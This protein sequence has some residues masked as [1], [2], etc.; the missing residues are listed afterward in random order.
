MA[1]PGEV[2]LQLLLSPLS[3]NVLVRTACCSVGIVLPVYSTFKAVENKDQIEQQKWLLY[4]A[5]YGTFSVAEVLTDKIIS[6]YY[7]LLIFLCSFCW[8]NFSDAPYALLSFNYSG[9][10]METQTSFTFTSLLHWLMFVELHTLQVLAWLLSK[11]EVIQIK[12]K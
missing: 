8:I 9:T 6:W 11:T 7:F 4:W 2:G 12:I 3:S 10:G 1:F 5:A